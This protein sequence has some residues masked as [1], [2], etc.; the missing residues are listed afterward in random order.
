[1]IVDWEQTVGKAPEF[2]ERSKSMQHWLATERKVS[3]SSPENFGLDSNFENSYHK[4]LSDAMIIEASEKQ[5]GAIYSKQ[6]HTARFMRNL[7][8]A[9][10]QQKC[11]EFRKFFT[12]L[13]RLTQEAKS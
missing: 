5:E 7:D 6:I 3:F 2:R 11:P 10:T 12:T 4:K 1:M 13:S 8:S 9:I